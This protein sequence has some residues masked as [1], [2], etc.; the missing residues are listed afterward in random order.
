[1]SEDRFQVDDITPEQFELQVQ[2]T[3]TAAGSSLSGFS[4]QHRELVRG[5]DGAY[6]VDITARFEALGAHFLVLIEC[7]HHRS[8]IKRE[9]VQVLY[10]RL[11]A[12]GAHK[13]M[14]WSTASFQK[15]AL[16]YAESHGIALVRVLDG[17]AVYQ[18]KAYAE[19]QRRPS[20]V[21][22]FTSWLVTLS[23]NRNPSYYSLFSDPHALRLAIGV[24]DG[25]AAGNPT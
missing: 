4:V 9:V 25:K 21:P 17:G 19:L 16:E 1:M 13:G 7:K 10:D 8:P 20:W 2:K 14:L 24:P 22:Q 6:E 18:T 11:R 12:V 3:L 5:S 23:E 15:G